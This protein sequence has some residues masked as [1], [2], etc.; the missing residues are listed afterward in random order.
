[1]RTLETETLSDFKN[2]PTAKPLNQVNTRMKTLSLNRKK[3]AT[4]LKAY[5][6]QQTQPFYF[7][8]NNDATLGAEILKCSRFWG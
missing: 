4:E 1:M 6:I 5:T 3:L 8:G 7:G 2:E